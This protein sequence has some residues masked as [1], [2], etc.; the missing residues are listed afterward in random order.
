MS[1]SA[2]CVAMKWYS[3]TGEIAAYVNDII[4]INTSAPFAFLQEFFEI[5]F[6]APKY[7]K[8]DF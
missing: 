2:L 5:H 7:C 8:S 6:L 4:W 3:A 1:T